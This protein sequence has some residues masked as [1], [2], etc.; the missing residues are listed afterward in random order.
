MLLDEDFQGD[1]GAL[2]N[3]GSGS[4]LADVLAN[5]SNIFANLKTPI[6]SL[7][8]AWEVPIKEHVLEPP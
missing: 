3:F 6:L 2:L 5:I 7:F 1:I 8:R 4:N